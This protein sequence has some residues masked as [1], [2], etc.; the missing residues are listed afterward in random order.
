MISTKWRAGD[1]PLP[2]FNSMCG[3]GTQFAKMFL[4]RSHLV[5]VDVRHVLGRVE[6][7]ANGYLPHL[8]YKPRYTQTEQDEGANVLTGNVATSPI[9]RFDPAPFF[10]DVT[11][12]VVLTGGSGEAEYDV[13]VVVKRYANFRAVR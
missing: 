7:D 9:W 2:I 10:M 5:F 6:P 8:Q 3:L 1:D 12:S 13:I 11:G 4:D